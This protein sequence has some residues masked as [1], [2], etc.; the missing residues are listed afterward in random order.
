[1]T[2]TTFVVNAKGVEKKNLLFTGP[3]RTLATL[4]TPLSSRPAQ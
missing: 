1:M 3:H 2:G 4:D